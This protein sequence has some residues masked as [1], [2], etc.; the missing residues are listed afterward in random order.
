MQ[1]TQQLELL[2]VNNHQ[3]CQAAEPAVVTQLAQEQQ[4][5][6]VPQELQGTLDTPAEQEQWAEQLEQLEPPT[7]VAL[8]QDKPKEVLDLAPLPIL[9]A[10]VDKVD[11]VGKV[12]KEDEDVDL[13]WMFLWE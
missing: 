10:T 11:K 13:C 4:L 7:S 5:I 3:A 6:K 1:G 8:A 9:R 2:T 12:D